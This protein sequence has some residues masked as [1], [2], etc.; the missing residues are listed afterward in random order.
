MKQSLT[1]DCRADEIIA[2]QGLTVADMREEVAAQ[3]GTGGLLVYYLSFPS[4][5]DVRGRDYPHLFAAKV[6]QL[7]YRNRSRR[8]VGEIIERNHA[9]ERI[10]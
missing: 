6:N 5:W 10:E 8:P 1:F 4:M 9:A 3:Q 2:G 7:V